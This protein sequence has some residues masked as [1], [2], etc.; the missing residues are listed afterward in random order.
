MAFNELRKCEFPDFWADAVCGVPLPGGCTTLSQDLSKYWSFL[1]TPP[2][3][4]SLQLFCWQ[5]VSCRSCCAL[6][7]GQEIPVIDG[8]VISIYSLIAAVFSGPRSAFFPL[9]L[10][11]RGAVCVAH[12]CI[13]AGMRQAMFPVCPCC[14][15]TG[16]VH[17]PAGNV[18]C[19][20]SWAVAGRSGFCNLAAKD[21][22]RPAQV[23][24]G[25]FF[26]SGSN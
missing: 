22:F 20:S 13:S 25:F 7:G 9:N 21:R 2:E 3:S 16:L 11:S 26:S 5:P 10:H 4:E 12:S 24:V 18:C 15:W 19:F 8:N 23:W 1:I 17:V 6:R 14:G